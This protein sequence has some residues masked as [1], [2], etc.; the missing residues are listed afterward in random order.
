MPKNSS[1]VTFRPAGEFFTAF[2]SGVPNWMWRPKDVAAGGSIRAYL[3]S[4]PDDGW[5][6]F[7]QNK[8]VWLGKD[9]PEDFEDDIGYQYGHGPGKVDEKTG[10][11]KED[12]DYPRKI[13]LMR[14][15]IVERKEMV[16]AVIDSKPLQMRLAQIASNPEFGFLVNEAGV[17][18]TNYY[19]QFFHNQGVAKNMTY[20]ADGHLRPTQDPQV[21][22][23]AA[24]PW[25]PESFW[26]G[27]NPFE[28]PTQP[29]ANAGKPSLP[30]TA[31]DEHG[32]EVPTSPGELEDELPW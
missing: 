22:E 4:P 17:M 15:W 25:H 31:F 6:Y 29:P 18:V 1:S 12:R 19:L 13:A 16:A 8:S 5:R 30:A 28:P 27:L 14:L 3:C 9:Y 7:R 23:E 24:K 20:T 32:A 21:W 11:P 2:E 10:E 26:L